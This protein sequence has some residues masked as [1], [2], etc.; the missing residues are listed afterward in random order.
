MDI[1]Q[2]PSTPLPF[3]RTSKGRMKLFELA[4]QEDRMSV[5]QERAKAKVVHDISEV[6]ED[7]LLL[8]ATKSFARPAHL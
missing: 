6:D 5:I 1:D 3:S 7:L 2:T 4:R 8:Q